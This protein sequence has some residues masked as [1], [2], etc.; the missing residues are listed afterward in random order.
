MEAIATC[1]AMNMTLLSPVDLNMLPQYFS[2]LQSKKGNF[3]LFNPS[4][5]TIINLDTIKSSVWTAGSNEG[6]ACDIEKTFIWCSSGKLI[7]DSQVADASFWTTIPNS[8][9]SSQRCLEL[10]Y[11]Q[12]AG[13]KLAGANC[14]QDKKSFV[15]Q[16]PQ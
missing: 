8:S 10:K 3:L 7:T 1:F 16:V 6:N 9:P 14:N 12:S 5:K 2:M 13:T 15:C 4:A 11:D